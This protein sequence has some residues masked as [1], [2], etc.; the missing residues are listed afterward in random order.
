MARN[1][2]RITGLKEMVQTLEKLGDE[3]RDRDMNYATRKGAQ[4]LQKLAQARAPRDSGRLADNIVVR[5]DKD[6][7]FDSEYYV[8]VRTV[9]K[10]DNPRNSFY[11]YFVEYGTEYMPAQPFMRPAWDSGR[12]GAMAEFKDR[13]GARIRKRKNQM[14]RGKL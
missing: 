13:I 4:S 14:A 3:I 9:G 11:A 5:K 2:S 6:T 12:T 1:Y 8:G 7:I 10:A